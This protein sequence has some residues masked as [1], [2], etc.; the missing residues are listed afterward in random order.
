[1]INKHF[2]LLHCAV[3]L[4][5]ALI[6]CSESDAPAPTGPAVR[7]TDQVPP[8]TPIDLDLVYPSVGGGATL[9]WTAPRDDTSRDTVHRYEIRY[10]H[11][12]PL[13]W[14]VSLPA[15]DPPQPAPAGSRQQ[16]S[17][18][19]PP[20]GKDLYVAI[21]SYDGAG[22]GSPPSDPAYVHITGYAVSGVCFE[23]LSG[24]AVEGIEVT[25]TESRVHKVYTDPSGF[26]QLDDLASGRIN[27]A[28]RSG[29]SGILF[30]NYD[31]ATDLSDK[32]TG[33]HPVVAYTPTD[34]PL[35][36]NLLK[37]CVQ[38]AGLTSWNRSLKKWYSYPIDVYVAPLVND[39][40]LDYGDSGR[41]AAQQ[42]N[43]RTGLAIFNVVDTPPENGIEVI[44]KTREEIEPQIGY[45][46]IDQ[47]D[48]GYPVGGYIH[49]IDDLGEEK[50]WSILLH[51]LG[52]TLRLAH[53]PRGYL[54]YASVP[55]PDHI[56]DD[57]VKLVQLF[58]AL[59]NGIDLSLYNT[60]PPT[61]ATR[62]NE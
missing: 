53:L 21:R 5:T 35:G 31:L 44:F 38:A 51:E 42:W 2:I 55:L 8:E 30:H 7:T 45:A 29:E 23:P 56:T 15:P 14:N 18:T 6:A 47:D 10:T 57:E 41:R 32:I 37:L 50:L 28:M 59:P 17:F 61:G 16:Y 48:D 43:D 3:V 60:S 19:S 34:N 25:V 49:I 9:T 40:G 46:H 24:E 36:Q 39:Q 54:M 62:T 26:F 11:S 1:M 52:H 13:D 58:M 22:N 33:D 4:L 20:R 27:I 12:L